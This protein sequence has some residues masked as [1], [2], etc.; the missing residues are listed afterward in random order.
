MTC[1]CLGL[2]LTF[3]SQNCNVT[4]GSRNI[5]SWPTERSLEDAL[6]GSNI[7]VKKGKL[8]LWGNVHR[9]MGFPPNQRPDEDECHRCFFLHDVL[10]EVAFSFV[11]LC[12]LLSCPFS[13]LVLINGHSP[14]INQGV[15]EKFETPG[16]ACL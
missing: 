9:N 12:S 8:P 14:S 15:G 2:N 10:A 1:L 7:G 11:Y 5:E 6:Q 3:V 4:V 16:L 13:P